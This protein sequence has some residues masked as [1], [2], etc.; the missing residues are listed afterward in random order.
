MPV[1]TTINWTNL[2]LYTGLLR[3]ETCGVDSRFHKLKTP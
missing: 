1:A 3:D 2:L